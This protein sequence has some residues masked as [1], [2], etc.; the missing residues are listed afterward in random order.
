MLLDSHGG[1][2]E[3]RAIALDLAD[4]RRF[5]LEESCTI[6]LELAGEESFGIYGRQ[7]ALSM[8][9]WISPP[10][11]YGRLDP[12]FAS[13]NASLR[14]SAMLGILHGGCSNRIADKLV[15]AKSRIDWLSE[16]REFR[17]DCWTFGSFFQ[18][19]LHYGHPSAEDAADIVSFFRNEATN[20]A[21]A[22]IAY[23]A[24]ML[25]MRDDPSWSTNEARRAMMEKWRDD[26]GTPEDVRNF[27]NGLLEE[28]AR[29]NVTDHIGE[30][31]DGSSAGMPA[32]ETAVEAASPPRTEPVPAPAEA[33]PAAADKTPAEAP[34][35]PAGFF[36][37]WIAGAAALALAA[38]L[39]CFVVWKCRRR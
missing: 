7:N 17:K 1:A 37:A 23:Q 11:G 22:E 19:V 31:A 5:P 33:K 39:A 13:T 32:E 12:F 16:H 34:Q 18:G 24:D 29:T 10:E 4:S 25:L 9:G 21:F 30:T 27:W 35:E 15:Y 8:Y 36:S 38:T 28:L 26:P 6:L 3:I 20:A 2:L 14:E